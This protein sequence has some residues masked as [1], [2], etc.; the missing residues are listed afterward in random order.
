MCKS[1]EGQHGCSEF[2]YAVVLSCPGD[3]LSYFYF[4]LI[5]LFVYISNDITLPGYPSTSPPSYSPS[6]PSPLTLEGCSSTHSPT[7]TSPLLHTPTLGYQASTGP[8]T[9]PSIDVR[10]NHPLLLMYLEP[11]IPPCILFGW[12]FSL[13]ELWVVQ[14]VDLV[15][16]MGLQSPSA[17]KRF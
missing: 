13:W 15:L 2:M 1:H 9:A 12:W 8:R 4:L 17:R 5:I 14:L 6:P 16:P 11:C 10:Q 3:S 7:P